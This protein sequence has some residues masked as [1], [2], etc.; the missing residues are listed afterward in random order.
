MLRDEYARAIRNGVPYSPLECLSDQAELIEM[1]ILCLYLAESTGHKPTDLPLVPLRKPSPE[2]R[3]DAMRRLGILDA[4]SPDQQLLRALLGDDRGLFDQA[5]TDRLLEY[6]DSAAGDTSP[7]SVLPMGILALAILAVQV[8]G[9]EL[10]TRSGY[11]PEGLLQAP[12]D[13]PPVPGV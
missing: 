4:L 13:T 7:R 11:L 12:P 2:E 9:W 1:E 6:R 3:A 8:H 5:L 10:G